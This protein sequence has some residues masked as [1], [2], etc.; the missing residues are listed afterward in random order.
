MIRRRRHL[1]NQVARALSRRLGGDAAAGII[2]IAVALAAVLVA[3]SPFAHGYHA[4]FHDPLPAPPIARLASLHGWIND[5]LM[6]VFFFTVGLE[7]KRETLDGALANAAERRLPILAAASGMAVPA[8]IFLAIAGTVPD[9]RPG[10][11]IPAAT[12]I[13]FAVGVIGLLG[14]R[15]PRSLRLFL[16]TV[17]IADDLG[18]VMIIALFYATE[19]AFGWLAASAAI[20]AGLLL[21]NRLRVGRASPYLL[22]AFALWYCVLHSGVHPTIA[23]VLAAFAIPFRLDT[24]GDSPLLRLEHALAPWSGYVIV[25]LFGFANAGVSLTGLGIAGLAAPLP[26]AVAA[27]LFLG[28]Q[29]GILGAILVAERSGFAPRPEGTSGFQLWG[30]ALLC[31]IGFTMSLFIAA[32]A[33]PARPE[34][35]EQAKLGVLLG[36]LISA[37]LGFAVLRLAPQRRA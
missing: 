18:S 23:G 6:P 13:A 12:D 37:V 4:L 25:P 5:G 14:N 10:W 2:L 26:L 24:A 29:A 28:K 31:G 36:S 1:A 19:L 7:I 34:L 27:G 35:V 30:T 22:L 33:F 32:L 16:L 17:A 21:L 8:L 11:A 9:L 3:N 15:V 20:L